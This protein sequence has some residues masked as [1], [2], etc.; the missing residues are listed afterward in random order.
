MYLH[1]QRQK[2]SLI[3]IRYVVRFAFSEAFALAHML[4]TSPMGGGIFPF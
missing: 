1:Y 4:M 3:W 2:K